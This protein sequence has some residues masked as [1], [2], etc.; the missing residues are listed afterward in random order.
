MLWGGRGRTAAEA[1]LVDEA[2]LGGVVGCAV[3]WEGACTGVCAFAVDGVVAQRH[4]SSCYCYYH[5]YYHHHYYHHHHI[6][7]LPPH[8]YRNR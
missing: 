7:T 5:Y 2:V 4:S 3:W 6:R 1:V 8:L